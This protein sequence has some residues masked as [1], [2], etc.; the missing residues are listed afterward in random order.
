MAADKVR[1]ERWAAWLVAELAACQVVAWLLLGYRRACGFLFPGVGF[2]FPE[3]RILAAK[4]G[5]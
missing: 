1:G 5:I 2:L 3:I 4:Q